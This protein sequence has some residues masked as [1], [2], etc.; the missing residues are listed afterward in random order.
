MGRITMLK[1]R[2]QQHEPKRGTWSDPRRGSRHQR[3]YGT[4]WERERKMVL[5]RDGGLCQPCLRRGHTTPNC[6]TVDHIVNLAQ[7]GS[8]DRRNLQTIC[9]PCHT[10]KTQAESRGETWD[11]ASG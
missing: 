2:L 9:C 7:G 8:H 3:G 6:N 1:G 4:Q 10:R 5:A 11:E